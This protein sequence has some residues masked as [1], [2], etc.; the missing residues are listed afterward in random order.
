MCARMC[1]MYVC[2]LSHMCMCE[3]Q[4]ATLWSCSIHL[5]RGSGNRTQVTRLIQ[6]ARASTYRAIL[7]TLYIKYFSNWNAKV[8]LEYITACL[9]QRCISKLAC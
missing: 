2:V 4:R 5:S 1:M 9:T 8:H 3:G 7:T 6:Q